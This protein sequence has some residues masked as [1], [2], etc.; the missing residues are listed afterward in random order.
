MLPKQIS[1]EEM[2]V[3]DSGNNSDDETMSTDMLKDIRDG[4]QY[5]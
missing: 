5:H 1:K 2:N 4:S 3:M